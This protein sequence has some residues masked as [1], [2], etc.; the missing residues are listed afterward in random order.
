[1]FTHTHINTCVC[2]GVS[3]SYVGHI[4]RTGVP[5]RNSRT[6]QLTATQCITQMYLCVAN[7]H[8]NTLQHATS[9]CNTP[10]HCNTLQHTATHYITLQHTDVPLRH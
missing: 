4:S 6:L 7:A 3:Y 10:A 8:C 2:W 1:M 5:C 9:H